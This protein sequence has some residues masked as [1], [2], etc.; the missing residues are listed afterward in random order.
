M[1]IAVTRAAG[2]TSNARFSTAKPSGAMMTPPIEVTSIGGVVT[3][4]AGFAADNR[5]F[6]V[7]PAA[8]VTAIVTEEGVLRP[9]FSFD[10]DAVRG[11]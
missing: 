10:V 3:A 5:A 4:P 9:P 8:L 2:V 1:T 11:L 7:T 6:D